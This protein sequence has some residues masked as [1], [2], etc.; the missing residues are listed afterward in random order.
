MKDK[1]PGNA[2]DSSEWK[3]EIRFWVIVLAVF[4]LFYIS[5][6]HTSV[7]GKVQQVFLSSGVI[8]PAIPSDLDDLP[9]ASREFYFTDKNARMQ[10]LHDYEGSVIFMNIWATWCP[11][12]VAEMPSIASLYDKFR[13]DPRVTFLLISMDE[14]FDDALSFMKDRNLDLPVYHYRNR[15]PDAYDSSVIPTTYVITPDG[16]LAIEKRGMA[17]Y[18]GREFINFMR[19]VVLRYENRSDNRLIRY[20]LSIS[21]WLAKLPKKSVTPSNSLMNPCLSSFS[22]NVANC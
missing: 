14:N 15:A 22:T 7:I 4:G 13:D 11:P 21:A 16:K 18:D 12:C 3:G 9:S 17:K 19:T 8:Q 20:P 6:Y 1:K 2:E 10:S 5:G